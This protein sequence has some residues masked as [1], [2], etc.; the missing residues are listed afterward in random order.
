MEHRADS[1]STTIG[2]G[3]SYIIPGATVNANVQSVNTGNGQV[4]I[5]WG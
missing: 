4:S 1:G 3:A 2:G 5:A